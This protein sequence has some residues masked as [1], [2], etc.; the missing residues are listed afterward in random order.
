MSFFQESNPRGCNKCFCFSKASTC[1]SSQFWRAQ[2]SDMNQWTGTAVVTASPNGG[3]A[4]SWAGGR[5]ST[6]EVRTYDQM[7]RAVLNNLLP[8]DGT[9]Y[10]SAPAIYLGNK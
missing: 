3:A 1:T 4:S 8:E 7:V 2:V 5:D 9:F 6:L 10:F